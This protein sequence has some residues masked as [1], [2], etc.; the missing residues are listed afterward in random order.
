MDSASITPGPIPGYDLYP[1]TESDARAALTKVFGAERG[2]QR[3]AEACGAAGLRVG[4]VQPAQLD[5]VVQ[6]LTTQGGAATSIARSIQIR[7]RTYARLA[8]NP[9]F[10]AGVRE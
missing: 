2:E 10:A 9:A 3:W 5:H 7:M 6:S 1:L 4:L 8:A